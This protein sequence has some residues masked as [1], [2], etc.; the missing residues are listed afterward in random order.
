VHF[1]DPLGDFF[2]QRIYTGAFA[3]TSIRRV[4]ISK[5][6]QTIDRLSFAECEALGE[7]RFAEDSELLKIGERTFQRCPFTHIEIPRTVEHIGQYAFRECP[8]LTSVTFGSDSRLTEIGEG[9]F[10]QTQVQSICLPASVEVIGASAFRDCKMLSSI[11]FGVEGQNSRLQVIKHSAFSGTQIKSITIPVTVHEIGA[12]CFARCPALEQVIIPPESRLRTLGKRAFLD[13][14]PFH[15][16]LPSALESV[17]GTVLQS[18][19][20]FTLDER[21]RQYVCQD[22]I[23]YDHGRFRLVFSESSSTALMIQKWI[24]KIGISCF[25]HHHSLVQVSFE[26][27]SAL[28]AICQNAFSRTQI[29]SIIIPRTVGVL[30]ERCFYECRWLSKITFERHSL[31]R[32]IESHAFSGCGIR[33]I[34]FPRRIEFLGHHCFAD[35]WQLESI[36]FLIPSKLTTIQDQAFARSALT[37]VVVPSPNLLDSAFPPGCRCEQATVQDSAK[38]TDW[39]LDLDDYEF[40]RNLVEASHVQLYRNR[41]TGHEVVVKT[42][43]KP[44]CPPSVDAIEK[45]SSHERACM[46][47]LHNHPCIVPLVG[48]LLPDGTTGSTI[49]TEYMSRGTLAQV[50]IDNPDWWTATVQAMAIISLVRGMQFAHFYN[51]LHRDLTPTNL[52]FDQDCHLRIGDFDSGKPNWEQSTLTQQIST[53]RYMAPEMYE[54]NPSGPAANVFSFGLILYEIVVKRPVFSH[55]LLPPALMRKV[56]RGDRADIPACVRPWVS[57]LIRL[58]WDHNPQKRPSFA[59]IAKCLMAEEWQFTDEVDSATV[60]HFVAKLDEYDGTHI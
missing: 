9:S 49:V 18:L 54:D 41:T 29:E 55:D 53:P 43:S 51:I 59:E 27:N 35:C 31:L 16:L 7:V 21:N 3:Q 37:K 8:F 56:I 14:Q 19:S 48:Y 24:Q 38:A 20:G 50:L 15:L 13:C 2:L 34:E 47:T 52:L 6:V 42:Y 33:E 40:V 45:L 28:T 17:D 39:I 5:T 44:S 36:C 10:C 60:R 22:S 32:K 11:T 4:F 12:D 25:A 26:H 46:K 1:D 58:C 30:N 23:L 57:H